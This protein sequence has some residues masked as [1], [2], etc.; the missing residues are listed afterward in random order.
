MDLELSEEQSSA[1]SKPQ[2]SATALDSSTTSSRGHKLAPSSS[3]VNSIISNIPSNHNGNA[4]THNENSRNCSPLPQAAPTAEPYPASLLQLPSEPDSSDPSAINIRIR[5]P[6]NGTLSRRFSP[7]D[8]LQA[9]FE[10]TSQQIS[11]PPQQI[12]L[13]LR[14]PARTFIFSNQDEVQSSFKMLG[15][16]SP[17]EMFMASV[18][19]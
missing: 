8:R 11:A 2:A 7:E 17:Q 5:T 3:T 15:V 6:Q 16:C 10:Y 14:F 18:I 9:L 1:I 12:Q 13:A 19:R 4:N